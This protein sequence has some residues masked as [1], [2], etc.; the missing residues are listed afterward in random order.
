MNIVE[1]PQAEPPATAVLD[2][3]KSNSLEGGPSFSLGNRITRV[4]FMLVWALFCRW[5]PPRAHAWRAAILRLFGARIARKV[6]IYPSV[7]IWLPAHLE[8]HEGATLGPG[9]NC[10]AMAPITI[11]K[12]A[13]VSQRAVLCAGSHD[14][15]DPAFQ[16]ITRPITIGP[17]AWVAAEAFVGPGVTLGEGAVLGARGV[18]FRDLQPWTVYA[19]NPCAEVARRDIRQPR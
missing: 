6:A 15:R 10:Y 9:V 17:K 12:G 16:L 5:T 3:R 18:A 2:A 13:I 1:S 14:Y 11:G 19:G 4:A 8:M 7:Q